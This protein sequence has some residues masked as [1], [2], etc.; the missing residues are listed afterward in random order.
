MPYDLI[1]IGG[2]LAGAALAK[3]VAER[4]VRALVLER[5]QS[6]RD[7]VRGEVIVS[8]GIAEAQRQSI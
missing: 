7:R 1:V 2:G 5:E 4:G 6:F 3:T 8:W